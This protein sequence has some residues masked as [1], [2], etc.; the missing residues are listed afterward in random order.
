MN[1]Q[2][3]KRKR[4]RP[5]KVTSNLITQQQ[6]K[7]NDSNNLEKLNMEITHLATNVEIEDWEQQVDDNGVNRELKEIIP[8]IVEPNANN[9][10]LN[11]S[12]E[13]QLIVLF[14]LTKR[15]FF[16]ILQLFILLM[17]KREDVVNLSFVKHLLNTVNL[18][19]M[20]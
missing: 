18:S 4:G 14:V 1:S 5:R 16:K 11:Q 12:K 15:I 2:P 17:E 3:L 9:G 20:T 6:S 19:L 13:Y 7:Q 8:N 10:R